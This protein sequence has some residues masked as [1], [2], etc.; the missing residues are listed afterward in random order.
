MRKNKSIIALLL[1]LCVCVCFFSFAAYADSGSS[2]SIELDKTEAKVGEVIKAT[3][4]I[5]NIKDFS[6]YQVNLRY[7]P[8]VLEAIDPAT[9]NNFEQSTNP[10]GNDILLNQSYNPL[11]IADNIPSDGLL[12]FGRSYLGITEYKNSGQPETSGT[13]AVINFKVIKEAA[14]E[15]IFEDLGTMP[16][17]IN[18]TL[19]F[20]WNAQ[21]ITS[22]Y[23]VKISPKINP[24]AEPAPM[25]EYT[26]KTRVSDSSEDKVNNNTALIIVILAV[27]ILITI[28]VLVFIFR[29]KGTKSTD[30]KQWVDEDDSDEMEEYDDDDDVNNDDNTQEKEE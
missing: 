7:N 1:S 2:I 28:T 10:G 13:L 9:N 12:N 19:L 8:A 17:S 11:P 14:T 18:G 30:D 29:G 15:L 25:P 3:L 24:N 23:D 22:G 6:G 4:K 5:N 27:V 21:Q 26:M 20:D 16:N